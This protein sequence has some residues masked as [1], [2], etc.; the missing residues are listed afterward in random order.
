M[1]VVGADGDVGIPSGHSNRASTPVIAVGGKDPS[2]TGGGHSNLST[3]L[4]RNPDPGAP[5]A[6]VVVVDV[7]GAVLGD[8]DTLS[9][10]DPHAANN[11]TSTNANRFTTVG[12][13]DAPDWFPPR[14]RA[15]RASRAR[16]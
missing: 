10:V 9:A 12:R 3:G 1:R 13:Y 4:P 8:V 7:V 16:R 11:S 15:G 6:D 5:G 14:L 2:V